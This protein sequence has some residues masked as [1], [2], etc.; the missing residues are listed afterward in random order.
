MP[1]ASTLQA[2]GALPLGGA[3]NTQGGLSQGRVAQGGATVP[4]GE[5]TAGRS[6][7]WSDAGGS[8]GNRVV[9]GMCE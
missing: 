2:G 4:Q 5:G 8:R 3:L 1:Q 7:G 9:E 6:W